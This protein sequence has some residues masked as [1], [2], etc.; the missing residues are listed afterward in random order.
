MGKCKETIGENLETPSFEQLDDISS[1]IAREKMSSVESVYR[2]LAKQKVLIFGVPFLFSMG[3]MGFFVAGI[4]NLFTRYRYNQGKK[5]N[6]N[7]N[8][9]VQEKVKTGTFGAFFC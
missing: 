2:K 4:S 1:K 3:F 6:E 8:I 9:F 7:S 5:L